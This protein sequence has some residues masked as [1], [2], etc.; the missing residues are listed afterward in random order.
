M[1]RIHRG[2]RA[3]QKA[4]HDFAE[5]RGLV[6]IAPGRSRMSEGLD[7]GELGSSGR[8]Q[9]PTS[10]AAR[11]STSS[12]TTST[13]SS[14]RSGGS[15][16]PSTST[17]AHRAPSAAGFEAE[18]RQVIADRCKDHVPES[19]IERIA[20]LIEA[21][22]RQPAAADP[23]RTGRRE[24]PC[25]SR[26]A[27]ERRRRRARQPGADHRLG[28]GRPGG[29]LDGRTDRRAGRL[30]AGANAAR[31]RRAT[32][33]A[34]GL[35]A[36]ATGLVVATPARGRVI[37]RAGV[38]ERQHRLVPAA[39][40]PDAGQA[41]RPPA[42]PL[43]P[44]RR[45][46]GSRGQLAGVSRWANGTAA[47]RSSSR[48]CRPACSASTTCSS[49]TGSTRRTR[50]SSTSSAPTWPAIEARH[51]FRP[52]RVP[53]VA[54]PPRADPPGPVHGASPGCA[55]TSCRWSKQGLEPLGSDPRRMVDGDPAGRPG[56]PGRAKPAA[57]R[58]R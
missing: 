24:G 41:G 25:P 22:Q 36:E 17:T 43:G 44:R 1:S 13:A 42:S 7:A 28:V 45:P 39:P 27:G 29:P 54:G 34:E 26:L 12:T 35:V 6:G 10:T 51:G 23:E 15:R 57:R 4:L 20:H 52:G 37:D 58:R 8:A 50:T 56:D 30:P 47:R 5:S 14:P 2:R 19:L 3:L 21:E 32:A 40:R 9:R 48:G 53:P 33:R 31:L 49:P 38:G 11:R 16:S 55:R 18:L 46:R